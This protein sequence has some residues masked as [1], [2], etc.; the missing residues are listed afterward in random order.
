MADAAD[1]AQEII[2]IREADA[3]AAVPRFIGE[4]A[5]YCADCDCVIPHAR[6]EALPG[7]Q[8]CVHCAALEEAREKFKR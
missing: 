6:R 3:I 1:I 2:E 7:V 5:F 4:S 8:L